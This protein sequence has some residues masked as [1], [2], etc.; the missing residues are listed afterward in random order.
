MER[1][2]R[3]LKQVLARRTP[4]AG[5]TAN[6]MSR[7]RAEQQRPAKRGPWRWAM[8]GAIAASLMV[9][10]FVGKQRRN[11]IE[12][13]YAA[14]QLMLSLQLAGSKIN[15]ARDAVRRTGLEESE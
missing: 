3:E 15:Q 13:E 4:P 7:V 1:L 10:V 8:V 14:D 2:E 11:R 6:V 5:F 12:A 9:G